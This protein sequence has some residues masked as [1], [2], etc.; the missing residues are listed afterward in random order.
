[1]P[2]IGPW[3]IALILAIVLLLFGPKKLPE[4]ASDMA[5]IGGYWSYKAQVLDKWLLPLCNSDFNY[6]IKIFG[7]QPWPC[8][9]YCGFAGDHMTNDILASNIQARSI[10]LEY[11]RVGLG[12]N[13]TTPDLT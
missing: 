12:I 6:N 9:Q 3:E 13:S 4:L 8:P 1:M 10:N 11:Q 7:N 2:F 5:F